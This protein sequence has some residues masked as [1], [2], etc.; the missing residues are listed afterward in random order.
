MK[1]KM[2]KLIAVVM[3]FGAAVGALADEPAWIDIEPQIL[4]PVTVTDSQTL[5]SGS[6]FSTWWRFDFVVEGIKRGILL[7]VR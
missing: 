6:T 7:I 2:K 4:P 5:E 1:A 3:T